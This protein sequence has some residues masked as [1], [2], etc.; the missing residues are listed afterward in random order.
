MGE[1]VVVIEL[2]GAPRE[3][4]ER[5]GALAADRIA[6]AIAYY[7]PAFE[8][9]LGIGW[10]AV[11]DRARTWIPLLREQ[12]PDLLEEVEGIAEGSGRELDEILALNARGEIVY[13]PTFAEVEPEGCTS[14][15]LC[16]GAAGDG[17]VY[18]GQNW[19]WRREIR[20]TIV[21]LRIAAP[22]K[23][24]VVQQVEAGQIGR[25]GA[26]SAG[27]SLQANGLGGRF[28]NEI[29][30]PQPFI[31]RR[32]LESATMREALEWATRA[33]PQIPSNLL[34]THRDGFSVSVEAT[35]GRVGWTYGE[36]G[37]IVHGNH[38]QAFMPAQLAD[39]YR[40]MTGDSIY[41]VP[42]LERALRGCR[43]LTD[44]AALRAAI[45]AGLRDHFGYPDAVCAH[46][47]DA[48]EPLERWET[49]TSNYVDLTTGEYWIAIGTPCDTPHER[50]DL[51][52]YEAI[53]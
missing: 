9:A 19:D 2:A 36:R 29:G 34:V 24:T 7:E 28:A 49:V 18:A 8:A 33:Q 37:L 26:S 39:R 27:I 16:D 4:G 47:N 17:H 23:P 53:R 48:V 6:R 32:I 43:E 52:L 3:R 35:P 51:N 14:F 20:D 22:G 5:Y 44:S 21:V 46:A 40:P 13:D 45:A 10:G 50:L 11:C 25:H 1:Q 38:Y 42:R 30:V 15:S 31:R 12:F 41:R